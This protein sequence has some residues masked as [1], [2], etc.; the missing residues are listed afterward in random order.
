V[1]QA[2]LTASDPAREDFF[3]VSVS[4]SGD[5]VVVGAAGD[6]CLPGQNCGSAY[7]YRFNGHTWIQQAKLTA[8]DAAQDEYFGISVFV[9]G[10]V[11]VVGAFGDDCGAA[12]NCG[13]AYVYRFN[14]STWVEEQKLVASDGT[15]YELVPGEDAEFNGQWTIVAS[16]VGGVP[17]AGS[18]QGGRGARQQGGE[19]PSENLLLYGFVLPF[20]RF[21]ISRASSR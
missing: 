14:D 12:L 5:V 4:V 17:G 8:S 13:S 6:D 3:G 7:V 16:N 19:A 9:S 11:A 21:T 20:H 15:A 10:T 2:K 18:R 1:Q